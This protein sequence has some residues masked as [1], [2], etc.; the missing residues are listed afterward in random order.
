MKNL[1]K[2]ISFLFFYNPYVKR[3]FSSVNIFFSFH[4]NLFDSG[5]TIKKQ[6][7]KKYKLFGQHGKF[8]FSLNKFNYIKDILNY[9]LKKFSI[10]E[11]HT[12]HDPFKLESFPLSFK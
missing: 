12:N 5:W 11:N 7:F 3:I 4:F 8:K 10:Y 2:F 6:A 9:T 1:W